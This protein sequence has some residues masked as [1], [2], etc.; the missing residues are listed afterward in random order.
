M[1]SRKELESTLEQRGKKYGEFK[2]LAP[3]AQSLKSIIRNNGSN[4]SDS[5]KEALEMIMHKVSRILN[6]DPN[7]IDHWHDIAGYATLEEN[8]LETT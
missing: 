2:D 8:I 7:E 6:G 3:I 4:L 1:E 5:Q